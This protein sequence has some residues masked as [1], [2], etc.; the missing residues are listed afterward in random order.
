MAGCLAA[1]TGGA[2]S[3]GAVQWGA[4]QKYFSARAQNMAAAG[5]ASS[6]LTMVLS[7]RPNVK[8]P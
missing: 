4:M 1:R 3:H 7:Y 6:L 5:A 2:G 8:E